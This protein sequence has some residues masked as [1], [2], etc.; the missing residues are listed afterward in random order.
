MHWAKSMWCT[1]TPKLWA[2]N[3][4]LASGHPS[5]TWNLEVIPKILE[6]LWTSAIITVSTVSCQPCKLPEMLSMY[7]YQT[8]QKST[9]WFNILL[10]TSEFWLIL[11]FVS[12]MKQFQIKTHNTHTRRRYDLCGDDDSKCEKFVPY[13]LLYLNQTTL[14]FNHDTKLQNCW[15]Q[16]LY[17]I[18]HSTYS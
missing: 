14:S 13:A 9:T 6:H 3:M 11:S 7:W 4:E 8:F 5:G 12:D 10:L 1:C 17:T 2:F 16:H 15:M 18:Y